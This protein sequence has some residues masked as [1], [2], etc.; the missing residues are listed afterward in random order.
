MN[1]VLTL[2]ITYALWFMFM[3]PLCCLVAMYFSPVLE[4]YP[5]KFSWENFNKGQGEIPWLTSMGFW[6]NHSNIFNSH[7]SFIY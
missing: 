2:I 7:F 6:S 3:L 5:N 4:F 1:N